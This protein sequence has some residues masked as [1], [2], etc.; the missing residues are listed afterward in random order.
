MSL[1]QLA[2][3]F[4]WRRRARAERDVRRLCLAAAGAS[5]GKA[6]EIVMRDLKRELRELDAPE[7]AREP[8]DEPES[9]MPLSA[10]DFEK[11]MREENG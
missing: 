7:S 3:I 9:Q 11:M 5:G 1:G 2:W 6:F 8:A 4:R 10:A